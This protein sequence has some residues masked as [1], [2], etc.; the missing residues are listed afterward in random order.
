MCPNTIF[1][2]QSGH[3][4]QQARACRMPVNVW[5]TQLHT[6]KSTRHT[7]DLILRFVA[8]ITY[9][10][11]TACATVNRQNFG[12]TP[13]NS[14]KHIGAVWWRQ[15]YDSRTSMCRC[16]TGSLGHGAA[17]SRLCVFC[18]ARTAR[19]RGALLSFRNHVK[20]ILSTQNL[21]LSSSF[22][23]DFS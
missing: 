19:I 16:Y 10:A 7:V 20:S 14:R 8:F 4:M 2:L 6:V 1:F 3:G 11:A 21:A 12:G 23:S 15:A 5:Q 17:Y 13:R 9:C 18:S 22:G